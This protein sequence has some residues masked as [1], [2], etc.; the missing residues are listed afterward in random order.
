MRPKNLPALRDDPRTTDRAERLRPVSRGCSH[1]PADRLEIVDCSFGAA[2]I[3]DEVITVAAEAV[4]EIE[5]G[6][7][8]LAGTGL[9][10]EHPLRVLSVLRS[11]GAV[12]SV[13]SVHGPA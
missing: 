8:E 1:P 5:S 11:R 2:G 13:E 4:S 3:K 6:A 12:R 7:D 10:G 9:E